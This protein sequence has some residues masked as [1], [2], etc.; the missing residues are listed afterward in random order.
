[1]H[2]LLGTVTILIAVVSYSLYF[3]DV[4]AG[5]T[6]P[7]AFTWLIWSFLNLFVFYAQVMNNGGPGAW[8]TGAAAIANGIIFLLALRYGE[9]YIAWLDWFCLAAALLSLAVWLVY[10]DGEASIL[11]ASAVFV[12]GFIPTFRKSLHKAHEETAITFG[13]NSVKFFIALF[14]LSSISITTAVYPFLLFLV[15][16]FFAGFLFTRQRSAVRSKKGRRKPVRS[17]A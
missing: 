12:I 1:M 9:R 13:L 8:V 17:T 2:V 11:L 14:A 15:N 3:R 5:K 7:H 10:P 6:K 4:L 16:G